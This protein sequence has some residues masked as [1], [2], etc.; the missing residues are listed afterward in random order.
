VCQY[1]SLD[2]VLLGFAESE[3]IPTMFKRL[4]AGAF[5]AT[6]ILVTPMAQTSGAS[7]PD[8]ISVWN[9]TGLSQTSSSYW[10]PPLNQPANYTLPPDYANGQAYIR[11]NV[12]SKPSTKEVQPA[13]CFWRHGTTRFQFET[14]ARTNGVTFTRTGTFYIALGSPDSWWKKNGTWSWATPASVGRIM[15]KNPGTNGKLLLS[16]KCGQACYDGNDLEQHVPIVMD[17]ELI[18]VGKGKT[19]N[20]PASWRG[21]CPSAWSPA[22]SG[23]DTTTTTVASPTNTDPPPTA[24]STTV[25]GT[26][27]T[28]T[29]TVT[30]GP[31][32]LAVTWSHPNARQFQ[33]RY[34]ATNVSSWIW[35]QPA[36]TTSRTIT[37]L[38]SGR[39]YDVQ[40][41]AYIGGQWQGWTSAV[42]TAG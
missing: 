41:R 26:A 35:D 18:F 17:S 24:G 6:G 31:S 39:R 21:G 30:P 13:I 12:T 10:E 19:L 40:V 14:C 5:V 23:G 22:C 7:G 15:I 27:T 8:Q 36:Q 2:P 28:P 33:L 1:C 42:A 16:S 38:T 32:S 3:G 37:G 9:A 25:P 34:K 20:P 11:I 4:L 29:V